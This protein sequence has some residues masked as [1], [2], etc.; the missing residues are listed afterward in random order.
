MPLNPRPA[1]HQQSF[2]N[3]KTKQSFTET[4]GIYVSG[5]REHNLQGINVWIPRN[6]ITVV[7]G[8]SGSGKSSLVFDTIYAEGQRRYVE[9][10]SSYARFFIAQ[11][12]KPDVDFITGLSPSTAIDQSSINSS[13]RST[14][15]TTTETYDYLRL[16]FARLGQPHCIKHNIPLTSVSITSIADEI[17]KKKPG[18]KFFVLAPIARGKKGEFTKELAKLSSMGFTRARIDDR[19]LD[20]SSSIKL[21]K[22]KDHFIDV[23]IDR[24]IVDSDFYSR[25]LSSLKRSADLAKG[26]IK[27]E[28]M[29]STKKKWTNNYSTFASCPI[30]FSECKT[31]EPKLFSFNNPKG[32]CPQCKGLGC[33]PAGFT[34]NS[35]RHLPL[36]E[37]YEDAEELENKEC[38]SCQGLRLNA[39]A[40]SVKIQNK[41]IA[42]LAGMNVE[43]LSLFCR[44]LKFKKHQFIADAILNKIQENLSFLLNIGLG[45]LSLDRSIRTVSGGEAQ[46]I[47]LM[48]QISS[49][50]IG[51]LY[52]LDEPSI[53]LHPR[54]QDKLLKIL[55]QLRDRGNTVLMV[56]HDETT[57]LSADHLIDLGPKAGSAGGKVTAVGNFKEILK[58]PDSI[59]GAYLSGKKTI[60]VP[61]ARKKPGRKKIL[62]IK[63]AE[64]HNLKKINVQIPL[65]CLT[66][67]TGVSGSGKSTLI[68]DTLY[69]ALQ[70]RLYKNTSVKPAP[71]NDITGVEFLNR[72][73]AVNQKPIGKTPR[74]I[75]ATYTGVMTK[76][77]ALMALTPAARM[78]G[79]Q[80]GDFS[81]NIKGG[82]CE[83]CLGAGQIKQEMLFLPSTVIVCDMCQ[84]RRYGQDILNIKY[85]GKNIHEILSMNISSACRFFKN[86]IFIQRPLQLMEE[87][88]LGY[89]TLGQSSVSLS[90]GEAQRI[91]LT[92]ELAGKNTDKTLYILDEPTR[93]LH[94]HDVKQLLLVLK[95]LTAKGGTVIVIE[96]QMDVIKACDYLIELG[97][98]GGKYG[99]RITAC[100]TPEQTAHSAQSSTAYFLKQALKKGLV[101]HRVK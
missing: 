39:F 13:P 91:K 61:T 63:G 11:M 80:P 90:G 72:V 9:S 20:L 21:A 53:G 84:G 40:L 57:I 71:F 44:Q 58:S 54:D 33:S 59:T 23:L 78:R 52:I 24:L 19:W 55:F 30:C 26:H 86:H 94:F 65:G 22:R 3:Q 43:D 46:R 49:P 73:K 68:I 50:L 69:K 56:E 77:R 4:K 100:G 32:A 76:I 6:K 8:L 45:Y 28:S 16:L 62:E 2:R 101:S 10:L 60:P 75:P 12:K 83:H 7:T 89:L 79:C 97:P 42:E 41:N 74:S 64:G 99:G 95:K 37:E 66:G 15:G 36:P 92:K 17:M 81:F 5:A 93:G 47:R 85:K 82:R 1:A 18:E 98:G 38:S 27:I 67:I 14:V 96:H 48:S 31:L 35:S 34:E 51:V 70:A 25:L 88:G 87:V 29:Q